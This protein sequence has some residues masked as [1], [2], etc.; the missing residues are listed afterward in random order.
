VIVHV[1]EGVSWSRTRSRDVV[2]DIDDAELNRVVVVDVIRRDLPHG[3]NLCDVFKLQPGIQ[4]ADVTNHTFAHFT[5][6][7]NS[8]SK[9][10]WNM[11]IDTTR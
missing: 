7:H 4:S 3:C 5:T 9:N 6:Q 1:L 8:Y 11:L 10:V 2:V